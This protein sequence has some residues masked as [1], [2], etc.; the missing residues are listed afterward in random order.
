LIGER[1]S[2]A[3]LTASKVGDIRARY[4]AGAVSQ[5]ALAVEFGVSQAQIWNIVRGRSWPAC[6]P[7]T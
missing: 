5:D 4:A 1:N 7:A 6:G 3:K 2:Q